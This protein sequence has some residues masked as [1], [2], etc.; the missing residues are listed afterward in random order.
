[1][2]A[3]LQLLGPAVLVVGPDRY[4]L[5]STRPGW[6][7]AYLG[8]HG[9]WVSRERLA[10][11]FRADSPGPVARHYLRNLLNRAKRLPH[12][13]GLSVEPT[14]CRWRIDTDLD[15]FRRAI[16]TKNWYEAVSTY[17]GR[18]LEGIVVGDA[19]VFESWMERTREQL[20]EDW[21][22]ATL[23]YAGD[24]EAS[25]RHLV[26]AQTLHTFLDENLLDEEVLQAHL[27]N[28]YLAGNREPAL[29]VAR[30]FEA[31][32]QDGMGLVPLPATLDLVRKIR[33]GE[34]VERHDK[35][36][37]GRR[38]WTDRVGDDQGELDRL[39]A[40]LKDPRNRLQ[41][42]I[43]SE[44]TEGNT[45]VLTRQV[46]DPELTNYAV[47][48]LAETLLNDGHHERAVELMVL[49]MSQGPGHDLALRERVA[50]MWERLAPYVPDELLRDVKAKW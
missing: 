2:N 31:E 36:P 22:H 24:Q 29:E 37:S 46:A 14:R 27:R 9:T 16:R 49:V 39:M 17:R 32:L 44:R 19:P 20:H 5:T 28:A 8:A 45:V 21:R 23:Q 35:P 42:V 50:R 4:P 47:V 25:G 34:P 6:L 10:Y 3:S 11:L 13:K 48:E 15:Q 1:M 38:R 7:L 40:L 33:A 26:A 41:T 30:R 43:E 18:F 12:V